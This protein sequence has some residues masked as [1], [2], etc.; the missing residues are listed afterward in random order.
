MYQIFA[1]FISRNYRT[2]LLVSVS[3]F[4]HQLRDATRRGLWFWPMGSTPRIPYAIYLTMLCALVPLVHYM[5]R[6]NPRLREYSARQ[7]ASTLEPFYE[8]V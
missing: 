1:L 4:S 5:C 2:G 6:D 8:V 7:Q 3:L